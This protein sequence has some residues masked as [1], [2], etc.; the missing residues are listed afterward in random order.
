[1]KDIINKKV[2]IGFLILNIIPLFF[3]IIDLNSNIYDFNL[4]NF[5]Y[6]Y[7]YNNSFI[8]SELMRYNDTLLNTFFIFIY[9]YC[10]VIL[11]NNISIYTKNKII[12][13]STII[14]IL[15]W[16]IWWTILW[17]FMSV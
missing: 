7:N 12:K 17:I 9:N 1:M 6:I 3:T 14:S 8:I 13:I 4:N 5:L 16:V 11:L 2:I 15:S 10:I